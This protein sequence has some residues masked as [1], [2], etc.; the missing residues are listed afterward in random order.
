MKKFFCPAA[1]VLAALIVSCA[2]FDFTTGSAGGG[3]NAESNSVNRSRSG[4]ITIYTSMYGDVIEDIERALSRYFPNIQIQFNSGGTGIIQTQIENEI[5]AGGRLGCDLILV[6]DPS[7]SMELKERGLLHQYF[8]SEASSLVFDYDPQG[9]WY[10]VRVSNMVLAYNP[11]RTPRNTLPDSFYAFANDQSLRGFISMSSPIT[12][13]TSLASIAALKE[14]YGYDYFTALGRQNVSIDSGAIALGKLETGEFK[15]VMVLEESIL[16]MRAEERSKLDIIYP[17]D[18]TIVIPSTIMI[19]N[20]KWSAHGNIETAQA[21]T[22]WFLSEEGQ[23][24]IVAGWMHSVRKNGRIPYNSKQT[25]EITANSMP[26]NWEALN[27]DKE[28]FR[29]RF[30]ES[31]FYRN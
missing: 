10:P 16:K 31:V 7:Y 2:A 21:I 12:S 26:L 9:Y 13:G 18:G 22:D 1:A 29:M 5:A 28:I 25:S 3:F 6:A 30:E 15:M 4:G 17:S 19:V 20:E 23:N 14:K 24:A 8:S 11:E 27:A